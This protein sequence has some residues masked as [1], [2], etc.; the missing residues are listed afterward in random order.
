M[1]GPIVCTQLIAAPPAWLQV[2]HGVCTACAE[3]AKR[4]LESMRIAK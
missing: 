4:E 1:R 3:A 2:S